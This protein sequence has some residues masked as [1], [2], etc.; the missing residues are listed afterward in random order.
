MIGVSAE[1]ACTSATPPVMRDAWAVRAGR[2]A[3]GVRGVSVNTTFWSM[4]FLAA[5]MFFLFLPT[6]PVKH[7]HSRNGADQSSPQR[8]GRVPSS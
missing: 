4:T 7:A 1:T 2:G 3:A 5:S 8:D 6:G